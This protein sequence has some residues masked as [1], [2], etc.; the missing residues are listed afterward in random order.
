MRKLI[1][2]I[3]LVAAITVIIYILRRGP[4]SE[5]RGEKAKSE[6]GYDSRI[7]RNPARI[8]YTK[9]ARCRMNCR[10]IDESEVKEILAEGVVNEQKSEPRSDP[11]PKY[12]L[13]GITRDQQRVRIIFADAEKGMVVVTVIDLENE[14]SCNC[15]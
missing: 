6:R 9:H 5:T 11:D 8:I 7:N 4:G 3:L 1:R 14:W 15:K 2:I 12:A 13:E 10:Q